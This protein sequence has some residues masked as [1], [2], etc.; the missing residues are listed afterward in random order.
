MDVDLCVCKEGRQLAEEI[1]THSGHTYHTQSP[2]IV[3]PVVI[4]CMCNAIKHLVYAF[5]SRLDFICL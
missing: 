4:V 1:G 3:R 2:S 5:S